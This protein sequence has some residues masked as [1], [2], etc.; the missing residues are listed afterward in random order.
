M[1][2]TFP[3]D[4]SGAPCH[5]QASPPVQQAADSSRAYAKKLAT[6]EPSTV[7]TREQPSATPNSS[8]TPKVS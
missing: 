7:S 4:G 5:W 3:G 1:T 2:V 6:P 8:G